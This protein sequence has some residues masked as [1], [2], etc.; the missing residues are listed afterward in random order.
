[1]TVFKLD[2]SRHESLLY[3]F[4]G[5]ADGANPAGRLVIDRMGN[6]YGTT[7]N[8]GINGTGYA[9]GTVF[10]LNPSTKNKTIL[11]NFSGPDGAYPEGGLVM[12]STGDLYG[13]TSY[14]GD[15]FNGGTNG[16]GVNQAYGTVFRLNASLKYEET[17]L[18]SF[19]GSD[20]AN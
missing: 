10:R 9:G 17:V 15:S 19:S 5:G 11:Y 14:G 3:E 4:K 7:I 20:G 18:H 6:L 13:T 1:G 2:S 16:Y 12:D 8:G